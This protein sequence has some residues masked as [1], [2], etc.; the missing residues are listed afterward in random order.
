[1]KKQ[2]NDLLQRFS[3][4]LDRSTMMK[5][6]GGYGIGY[7]CGKPCSTVLDCDSGYKCDRCPA[8]TPGNGCEKA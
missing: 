3:N 7:T 5:I 2:K 6:N 4:V 8:G 1:M